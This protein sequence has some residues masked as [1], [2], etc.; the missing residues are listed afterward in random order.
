MIKHNQEKKMAKNLIEHNYENSTEVT[1]FQHN[2]FQK[3]FTEKQNLLE[4]YEDSY[5]KHI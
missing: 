2:K 1:P 4:P 3:S 5:R